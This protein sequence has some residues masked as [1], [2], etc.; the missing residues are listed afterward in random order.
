MRLRP[1]LEERNSTKKSLTTNY[2]YPCVPTIF[3]SFSSKIEK[4]LLLCY[5]SWIVG[6][7]PNQAEPDIYS[8]KTLCCLISI[9]EFPW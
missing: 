7:K 3:V 6:N 8:L 5:E 1:T 2:C 4:E 9:T